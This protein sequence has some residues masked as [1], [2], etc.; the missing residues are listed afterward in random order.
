MKLIINGEEKQFSQS[1]LNVTDLLKL[2]DVQMPETVSVQ[3]NDDFIAQED[4]ANTALKDGDCVNFLYF[5]G[6][7]NQ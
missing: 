5:M 3:I 6:G 4:Y 1:A 7:G 2:E